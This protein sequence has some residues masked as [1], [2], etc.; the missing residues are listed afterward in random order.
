MDFENMAH[1]I[2]HLRDLA[3]FPLVAKIFDECLP[4]VPRVVTL[5]PVC[6]PT[7]LIEME[8]M[9][10]KAEDNPQFKKL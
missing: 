7:W 8:C 3:D 1:A 4:N 10:V 9:A 2:V 5:A 6:R